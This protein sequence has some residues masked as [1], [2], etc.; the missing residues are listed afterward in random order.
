MTDAK[1]YKKK[2]GIFSK[3]KRLI[4]IKPK[5]LISVLRLEG[6]IM[7]SG[8]FGKGE[9]LS[10]QGL[11]KQIKRAFELPGIDAVALII[12]SPGGS[13]SQTEMIYDYIR[14]Y[15]KKTGVPV[16]SFAEEYAA[17]GGYWLLC[18][19]DEIYAGNSSI[20]GSIGVIGGGFGFVDAIKKIGVERRI[21]AQ[22]ENKAFLDPFSKENPEHVQHILSIQKVIHDHFKSLVRSRREGKLSAENEKDLFSGKVWCGVVAKELGLIDGIGD[23][24]GTMR[25]KFG[26]EVRFVHVTKPVGWL[27]RKLGL[28]MASM[29]KD[30][31]VHFHE[32]E[33]KSRIGL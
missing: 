1:K 19:G 27:K 29:I 11:E 17:S 7:S 4:G 3:L 22:G 23:V 33:L 25:E 16:Y 31:S 6:V 5:P 9:T 12:E 30:A 24:Y 21:Y 26:D 20:V 2:S 28:A 13:A 8:R 14:Y 32:H 15:A 10:L 18:A